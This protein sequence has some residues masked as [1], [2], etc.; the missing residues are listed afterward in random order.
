MNK[1]LVNHNAVIHILT[2]IDTMLLKTSLIT[3]KPTVN[4]DTVKLAPAG[5]YCVSLKIILAT[6]TFNALHFVQ[7][8]FHAVSNNTIKSMLTILYIHVNN[9]KTCLFATWSGPVVDKL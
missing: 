4:Y 7:Q 8:K 9:L 1:L 3:R 2:F 6:L 5:R